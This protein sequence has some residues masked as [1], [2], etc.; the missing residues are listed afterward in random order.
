MI[1]CLY[2]FADRSGAVNLFKSTLKIETK[3]QIN[4]ILS[5]NNYLKIPVLLI[6]GVRSLKSERVIKP[7]F[8]SYY[9]INSYTCIKSITNNYRVMS[10]GVDPMIAAFNKIPVI[11]GYHNLYPARYKNRFRTIIEKQIEGNENQ[12][13][14]DD[15]G[16][17]VYTFTKKSDLILLNFYEAKKIGADYVI[18]SFKIQNTILQRIK[19]VCDIDELYL[20][21]IKYE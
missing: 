9:R 17:R 18:S 19:P 4:K 13:Y 2:A 7:T 12:S 11:D 15:W 16:S 1:Y 21:E 20:Y 8:D 3:N 10:I 14:F 6:E 5:E